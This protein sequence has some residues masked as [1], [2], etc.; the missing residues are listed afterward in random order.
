VLGTVD[1]VM[2]APVL[3]RIYGADIHV[4]RAEGH[5]FVMSRGSDV[6][7]VDHVHDH[8]GHGHGHERGHEHGHQH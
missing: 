5:I 2:R 3:S 6:E 4:V 7:R 8:D 1:D